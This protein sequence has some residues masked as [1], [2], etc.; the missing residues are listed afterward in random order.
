MPEPVCRFGQVCRRPVFFL[1][2]IAD[3]L[4][5]LCVG[6]LIAMCDLH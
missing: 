3:D 1:S 6:E 4:H 5:S 2:Q